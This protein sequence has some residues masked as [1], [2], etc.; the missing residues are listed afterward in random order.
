MVTTDIKSL[1][2]QARESVYL[3]TAAEGL[4]LARCGEALLEYFVDKSRGTPGRSRLHERERAA[5]SAAA[6][7]LG[8]EPAN[9]ALLASASDALN[10]FAESLDWKRGDEVVTTDLEFPSGVLTWL[11]LRDR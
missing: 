3:D 5:L 1:F 10:V 11:R 6:R 7:L 4:P 9:V 8:A 2:V